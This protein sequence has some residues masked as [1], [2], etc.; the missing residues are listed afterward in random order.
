M[1]SGASS[2][3]VADLWQWKAGKCYMQGMTWTRHKAAYININDNNDNILKDT[4]E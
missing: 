1:T 3:V 2:T 4:S